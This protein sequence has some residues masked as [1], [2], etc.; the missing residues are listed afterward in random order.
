MGILLPNQRFDYELRLI[1]RRGAERENYLGQITLHDPP[2]CHRIGR[3]DSRA[4]Y[5]CE[6]LRLV[7]VRVAHAPRALTIAPCDRELPTLSLVTRESVLAEYAHENF[8]DSYRVH[9]S[10]DACCFV[11]CSNDDHFARARQQNVEYGAGP[12]SRQ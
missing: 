7:G 5:L 9:Y 1:L 10:D 12:R 2:I 11:F 4:A 8:P 3:H 6:G